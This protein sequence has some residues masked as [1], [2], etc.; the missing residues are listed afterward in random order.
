[1]YL[2]PARPG[3]RDLALR[4]RLAEGRRSAL[5]RERRKGGRASNDPLRSRRVPSCVFE[6]D[7]YERELHLDKRTASR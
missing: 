1:M 3:L 7:V 6:A 4:R 5:R 2:I